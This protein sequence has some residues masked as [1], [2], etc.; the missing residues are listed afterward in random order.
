MF[1]C[2]FG[3]LNAKLVKKG[4]KRD[5]GVYGDTLC[6]ESVFESCCD[7]LQYPTEKEDRDKLLLGGLETMTSFQLLIISFIA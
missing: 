5:E 6:I 2:V 4:K 3:I 1:I 7:M